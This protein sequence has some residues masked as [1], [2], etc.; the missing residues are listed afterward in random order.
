VVVTPTTSVE[1]DNA[2]DV[3]WMRL[4]GPTPASE[5]VSL[6]LIGD[7][8]SYD[9]TVVDMQGQLVS[10]VQLGAIDGV[11]R[12]RI[13]TDLLSNGVYIARVRA[14]E[15]LGHVRFTVGR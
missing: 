14:G 6:E 8:A 5:H 10:T 12:V 1:N 7:A 15:R 9:V 13:P 11:R 3:A 2:S 4:I